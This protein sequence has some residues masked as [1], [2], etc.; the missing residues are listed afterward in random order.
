MA[1]LT[2]PSEDVKQA[3]RANIAAYLDANDPMKDILLASTDVIPL[4]SLRVEELAQ[5]FDDNLEPTAW[6]F[7]AGHPSGALIAADVAIGPPPKIIRVS[8]DKVIGE[9]ASA[10][11]R[12]TADR[13]LLVRLPEVLT[14]VFWMK[15]DGSSPI[16]IA[17]V[18]TKARALA[19]EKEFPVD[20]FV[21]AVQ[22][23]AE[24]FNKPNSPGS[25]PNTAS[26][27]KGLR[28]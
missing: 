12:I 26:I 14:D 10:R 1:Q 15:K 22:A 20:R 18:R 11:R 2:S 17:P 23:L 9:L 7:M 5:L 19:T 4:R 21:T 24:E 6:R 8:R 28:K 27:S 16:S 25:D 13:L 3:L